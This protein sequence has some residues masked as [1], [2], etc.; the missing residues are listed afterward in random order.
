M[1]EKARGGFKVR[2]KT[3]SHVSIETD[4]GNSFTE[5]IFACLKR[6]FIPLKLQQKEKAT[7]RSSSFGV[8]VR[9]IVCHSF[10]N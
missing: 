2:E 4:T 9:L 3:R 7:A 6:R 5:G 8:S 1:A 10:P